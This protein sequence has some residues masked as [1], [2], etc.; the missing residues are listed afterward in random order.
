MKKTT[1]LVMVSSSVVLLTSSISAGKCQSGYMNDPCTVDGY[2]VVEIEK[3][4]R[5]RGGHNH[6]YA[7]HDFDSIKSA[8]PERKTKTKRRYVKRCRIARK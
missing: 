6:I 1:L 4:P 7:V 8:I 2:S 5:G 3:S